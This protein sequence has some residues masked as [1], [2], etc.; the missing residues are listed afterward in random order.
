MKITSDIGYTINQFPKNK[1]IDVTKL[2]EYQIIIRNNK[3]TYAY[4]KEKTCNK[5]FKKQPI[6]EFYIK[7]KSTGRRNLYC[8]D[9]QMKRGG[10]IEIGKQ[11]FANI[12]EDKGFRRCSVCKEIK[13]LSKFKK[14]KAQKNGISNTCYECSNILHQ[15]YLKK[16]TK[17]VGNFY[18]KQYALSKYGLRISNDEIEKY[19][20]EIIRNRKHKYFIE[21]KSF[22]TA[23]DFAIYIKKTYNIPIFRTEKRL[24]TGAKEDECTLPEYEYRKLKSGGNKGNIRVTDTVTGETFT[25]FNTRDIGL[26]KMFGSDTILKGIKSGMPIG[27]KRSKYPNPCIIERIK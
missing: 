14:H 2:N 9:C 8:R 18:V 12:I 20:T 24:S 27:G 7:D 1:D 21:D 13:P 22:L 25:F 16:Q 10:V 23:R 26:L 4:K 11:R 19:R 3:R 15:K 6:E 5:C 17:Q